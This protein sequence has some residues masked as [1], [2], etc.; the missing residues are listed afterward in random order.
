MQLAP[1]I[2]CSILGR[3]IAFPYEIWGPPN[4]WTEKLFCPRFASEW[5]LA[6]EEEE[7]ACWRCF[8]RVNRITILSLHYFISTWLRPLYTREQCAL[9]NLTPRGAVP[10]PPELSHSAVPRSTTMGPEP[11]TLQWQTCVYLKWT[12]STV[13][14]QYFWKLAVGVSNISFHSISMLV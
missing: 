10:R 7:V 4:L 14:V 11:G 2:L 12:R 1:I 9:T 3:Y 8:P 13:L 5:V 6:G